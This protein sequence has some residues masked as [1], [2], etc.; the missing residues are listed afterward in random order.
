LTAKLTIKKG[1]L[2]AILTKEKEKKERNNF[3]VKLTRKRGNLNVR[4]TI[5]G[6]QLTVEITIKGVFDCKI[7]NE[8]R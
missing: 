2:A 8:G 4:L 5:K 1:Y 7:K 3:T 6:D